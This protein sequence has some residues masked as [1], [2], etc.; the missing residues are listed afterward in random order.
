MAAAESVE[1]MESELVR[2]VAVSSIA[3]LA[4]VRASAWLILSRGVDK[5][6][7]YVPPHSP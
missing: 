7:C 1:V 5:I 3:W 6:A 4:S 2:R